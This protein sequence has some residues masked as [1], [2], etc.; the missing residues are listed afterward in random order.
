MNSGGLPSLGK[1]GPIGDHVAGQI[2]VSGEVDE[3]GGERFT[4][5][6]LQVLGMLRLHPAGES[7]DPGL[8]V[9]QV[10]VSTGTT[11]GQKAPRVSHNQCQNPNWTRAWNQFVIFVGFLLQSSD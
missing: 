10:R 2:S 3:R 4:E 5:Q 11:E 9:E 1:V 7:R 8:H 6:V